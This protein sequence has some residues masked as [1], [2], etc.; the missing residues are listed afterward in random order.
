MKAIKRKQAMTAREARQFAKRYR[1]ALNRL[2]DVRDEI[3]NLRDEM[4]SYEQAS[5]DGVFHTEKALEYLNQ[6]L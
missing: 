3:S 2:S 4:E 1:K 5:D 6:Y